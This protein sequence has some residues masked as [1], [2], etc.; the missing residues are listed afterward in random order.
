MEQLNKLFEDGSEPFHMKHNKANN[1]GIDMDQQKKI[2]FFAPN[3]DFCS[4]LTLEC[5]IA[6]L[7]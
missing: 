6:T 2:V 1:N 5:W 3:F 4:D 7:L